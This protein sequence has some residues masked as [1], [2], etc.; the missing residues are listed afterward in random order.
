MAFKAG[1]TL[2]REELLEHVP[3]HAAMLKPDSDV[4][5]QV[6]LTVADGILREL[7]HRLGTISSPQP[8]L[9]SRR[10]AEKYKNDPFALRVIA[11]MEEVH[12]DCGQYAFIHRYGEPV[13]LTPIPVK[14]IQRFGASARKLWDEYFAGIR[15][16]TEGSIF[17][18]FRRIAWEGEEALRELFTSATLT[19]NH[20]AFFD[21]RFVNYLASNFNAVDR[22]HWRKFEGMVAEYFERQGFSVAL[23]KG[24]NDGGVDIRVW[25]EAPTPGD[26]AT[27]LVQCK[28]HADDIGKTIVKA[29]WADL[30]TEGV[31][32]GLIVT[33][34]KLQP[35]AAR[36]A[37]TLANNRIARGY[38]VAATDRDKLHRW[39]LSMRSTDAGVRSL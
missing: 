32:T 2:T 38:R 28:R 30:V 8:S 33:T 24:Q 35:G 36:A 7:L 29:L 5:E 37:N 26:P 25:K 20:G 9:P 15:E 23:G 6:D 27:I 10:L 16:W 17:S 13:D 14:A 3:T 21:Q 34:H 12:G 1:L 39:V 22:M 11:F 19:T 31:T 18:A 4:E